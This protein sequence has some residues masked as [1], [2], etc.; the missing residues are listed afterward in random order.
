MTDT[1][2]GF[3]EVAK[4]TGLKNV[5]VWLN[6]YFGE[7]VGKE[8]KPFEELKIAQQYAD[9]LVGS[10]TIRERN[11]NTFG[12]DVKQMLE[13]RLTFDSAIKSEEFSLVAKQRLAI[14]R[15]DL[16]EQIDRLGW[17]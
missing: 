10:I 2:N 12:D 5:V 13:R 17:S 4:T 6:E 11:S 16:F 7:V 3:G 14:V 15:R 9:R 1:L 8:G